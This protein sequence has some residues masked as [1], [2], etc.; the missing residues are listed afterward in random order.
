MFH[1]SGGGGQRCPAPVSTVCMPQSLQLFRVPGDL[2]VYQ[3][4]PATAS[5]ADDAAWHLGHILQLL[6]RPSSL[7]FVCCP[8]QWPPAGAVAH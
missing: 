3:T 7:S 8:E 1:M 4:D 6:H 2:S 5:P